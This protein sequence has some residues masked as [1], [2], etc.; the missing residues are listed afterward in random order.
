L[1]GDTFKL[2]ADFHFSSLEDFH[3]QRNWG[4][5]KVVFCKS[6]SLELFISEKPSQLNPR[7]LLCGNSDFDFHSIDLTALGGT[8][9]VFL[10]NSFISDNKMIFTLP[11]GLENARY[12]SNGRVSLYSKKLHYQKLNSVLVGPFGNTHI[13]R[14]Q[15]NS[16]ESDQFLCCVKER[17]ST[18]RHLSNIDLHNFVACPRG[19]G[20]DTHRVW[21]SLYRGSIPVL[22]R[23]SWSESLKNFGFPVK[24]INDWGEI[25]SVPNQSTILG[26]SQVRNHPFLWMRTWEKMFMDFM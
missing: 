4:E 7:V 22:V 14:S 16:L 25:R 26:P 13:E 23:N 12:E 9:A 1:S 6:D 10:Q 2:S 3:T 11:I 24:I 18:P 5:K 17:V 21:E 19:N 20:V 15:L 8:K